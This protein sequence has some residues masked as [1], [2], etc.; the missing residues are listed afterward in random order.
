MKFHEK[1]VDL[2]KLFFIIGLLITFVSL[3][4]E[5]FFV[6]VRNESGQKLLE[7]THSILNGWF[8]IK[9]LESSLLDQFIPQ[10]NMIS[11]MMSFIQVFLIISSIIIALFRNPETATNLETTK[12]NSYFFLTTTFMIIF[13]II[14]FPFTILFPNEIFFP[15]MILENA[16][17]SITIYQGIG[18]GYIFQC[19]GFILTF[20]YSFFCYKVATIFEQHSQI[21]NKN[22]Q[23][24]RVKESVNLDQLIAEEDAFLTTQGKTKKVKKQEGVEQQIEI[25]YQQFQTQ[26]KNNK[27]V[28]K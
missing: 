12:S 27:R 10:N 3:F 23:L 4:L 28:R 7:S 15:G 5:W 16:D 14:T 1:S 24:Q 2:L 18:L 21:P 22:I 9:F 8:T 19:L 20:P 13:M 11:T 17:L 26:R 6:E 25:A